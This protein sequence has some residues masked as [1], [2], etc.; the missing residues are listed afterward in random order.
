MCER[1]SVASFTRRSLLATG[2]AAAATASLPAFPLWAQSPST[3]PN[4]ISPDEALTR[5]RQGNAR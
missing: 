3:P 1:C 5:L 2:A 4:A